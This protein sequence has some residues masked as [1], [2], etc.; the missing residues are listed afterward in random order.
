MLIYLKNTSIFVSYKDRIP[1][2]PSYHVLLGG[3]L[4]GCMFIVS[5]RW[6]P[7]WGCELLLSTHVAIQR[8]SGYY[9]I[10]PLC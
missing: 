4:L 7:T 9:I 3:D 5:S 8:K 1:Y 6:V 10:F 2:P